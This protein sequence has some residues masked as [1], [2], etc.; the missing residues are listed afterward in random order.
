[1]VVEMERVALSSEPVKI[2]PTSKIGR[3]PIG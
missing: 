3:D 1:L 2:T